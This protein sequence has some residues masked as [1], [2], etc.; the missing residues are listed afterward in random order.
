MIGVYSTQAY[1]EVTMAANR[2]LHRLGI[3]LLENEVFYMAFAS[4]RGITTEIRQ[5]RTGFLLSN[6]RLI[7]IGDG[8]TIRSALLRDVQYLQVEHRPR[9]PGLLILSVVLST[10]GI[11]LFILKGLPLLSA[12]LDSGKP[13]IETLLVPIILL[14]IIIGLSFL[15]A[16]LNSGKMEISTHIGGGDPLRASLA[17]S[18]LNQAEEFSAAFFTYKKEDR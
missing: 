14:T 18:A 3:Q 16:W 15:G 7:H 9:S 1:Q 10:L 5:V 12:W 8:G 4:R 6:Q 11:L 2:D 17:K 13:E